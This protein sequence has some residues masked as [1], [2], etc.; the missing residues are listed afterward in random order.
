MNDTYQIVSVTLNHPFDFLLEKIKE[1]SSQFDCNGIEEF[2]VE[3]EQADRI[4]G[5]RSFSGG[6]LSQDVLFEVEEKIK[7]EEKITV[8]FFFCES[9]AENKALSFSQFVKDNYPEVIIQC[10][11]KLQEDW[12][13]KWKESYSP[14]QVSPFIEI[15]P[16]WQRE[17]G[18]GPFPFQIYIYPGMAF[19]TGN[20]ETTYLCL[21]LLGELYSRANSK[22]TMMDC[23]DF[24]CGSGILGITAIKMGFSHGDLYDI[25]LKALENAS[26]NF[27]LNFQE[28]EKE[29]FRFLLPDQR[30]SLQPAY[31][32][33]FA[34]I[35]QNVLLEEKD[36][37]L[38][39]L[40]EGGHLILSGILHDQSPTIKEQY[41]KYK[42][43]KLIKEVFKGDWVAIILQR[44]FEK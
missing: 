21:Q 33:I 28:Q 31:D 40:K 22:F 16:S 10:E 34:N 29:L 36:F 26:E 15:I 13:A 12:N 23:L 20:H 7:Q 32:L 4:L 35:L 30:K 19:G 11:E 3:E 1:H 38:D 41:L 42:N 44:E 37:F 2:A 5:E 27:S 17:T 39:H 24:G 25:D 18:T 43:I 9:D 6:D 14:I 8:K